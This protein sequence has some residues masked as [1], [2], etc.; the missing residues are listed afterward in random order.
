MLTRIR[1]TLALLGLLTLSACSGRSI[2]AGEDGGVA[3][4]AMAGMLILTCV[5]LWFFLGRND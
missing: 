4:I 3:F 1:T 2:D 5:I